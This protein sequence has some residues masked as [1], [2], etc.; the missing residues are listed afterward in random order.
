MDGEEV[1]NLFLSPSPVLAQPRATS[2]AGADRRSTFT[3]SVIQPQGRAGGRRSEA[4]QFLDTKLACVD[5]GCSGP[6]GFGAEL[7][8]DG[9]GQALGAAH[10]QPAFPGSGSEARI[11]DWLE[12][13]GTSRTALLRPGSGRRGGL[14]PLL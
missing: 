10:H 7:G 14:D 12:S 1:I 13:R 4:S 5:R 11:P 9:G 2:G 8:T 6:L 3:E